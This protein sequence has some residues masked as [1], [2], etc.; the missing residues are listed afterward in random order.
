MRLL[1]RPAV[2]IMDHM[3]FSRKFVLI[4]VLFLIP[5]SVYL[6]LQLRDSQETYSIKFNQSKGIEVN[7]LLRTMIQHTQEH[8]GMSSAYLNGN[9][10]FKSDLDQKGEELTQDISRLNSELNKNEDL[11]KITNEWETI[12]KDLDQIRS[13][14]ESMKPAESF[15][16]HTDLIRKMLN[17]T[18]TIAYNSSVFL[19]DDDSSYLLVEM[20]VKNLP[21]MTEMMG[22]SRA[23]GSGVATKKAIAVEETQQLLNLVQQISANLSEVDKNMTIL[24]VED[25]TSGNLKDAYEKAVQST[26]LLTDTISKEFIESD[27]IKIDSK[28]YF[29]LATASINDVYGFLNQSAEFLDDKARQEAMQAKSAMNLLI[30]MSVVSCLLIIYLFIGFYLSIKQTISSINR[31][32]MQVANGDLRQR[33]LL[34]SKD[35]TQ[36]IAAAFNKMTDAFYQLTKEGKDMASTLNESAIDLQNVT[37]HTTDAA[38]KIAESMALIM[39]QTQLQLKST[40]DVSQVMNQIAVGVQEIAENSSEVA[41]ASGDMET[42]VDNGYE[43]LQL[44]AKKMDSVQEKVDESSLVINRLGDRSKSIG[45]ILETIEAIASQTNLLALNAAIE[46]ARAGEHGRGF[47]VVADEVRKLAELSQLSTEKVSALVKGIKDD[48]TLSV[49]KMQIVKT[50]TLQGVEQIIETEKVFKKINES[51]SY[52]TEQIQGISAST[53]EISASAEEITST[54]LEVGAMAERNS[55]ELKLI[56]DSTQEQLGSMEEATASAISLS[57]SADEL[58]RM[59]KEYLV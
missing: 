54:L 14:L 3:K 20:T 59:T 38:Q 11:F 12:K 35:E 57:N 51:T 19:Q 23:K 56:S 5:L 34:T 24:L 18:Q 37:E 53:Q 7:I 42:A 29:D 27:Q 58:G 39:E 48:V 17:L 15:A 44:L 9:K 26:N 6:T 16:G 40:N 45:E 2:K 55:E 25:S 50:E 13:N 32:A 31:V 47:S 1:F 21:T 33:I 36:E 28:F 46:A 22:Q 10:D 49:S 41:A 43:S 52:V 8:R 30:A 4:F